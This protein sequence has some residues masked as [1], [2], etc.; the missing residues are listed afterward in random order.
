MFSLSRVLS[1]GLVALPY[2]SAVVHDV[3]VGAG[4]QLAFS[5]EAIA[6][7]PGDQV[8]FHF[9]PKNHT[10]TQ[11][12]FANPCG[13]KQG[14][15]DSGF[16]PVA[17]NSTQAPPTFAISVNDTQPIWV[18]CGQT[19]HCGKGMVF[20]VN[21]GAD[22]SAN[23]FTNFKKAALAQGAAASTGYPSP[24]TTATAPGTT[25]TASAGGQV[26]TVIVGGTNG[27]VYTPSNITAQPGDIVTFE[28]HSKNHTA[29]QSSFGA[30]CTPLNASGA[31]G[32]D[33]GFFP[34]SA[35]ATTFPTWNFT[36]QDT[37]PVWAYCAQTGHCRSGMVFAINA[38]PNSSKSYDAFLSNAKSGANGT[39]SG[40][41]SGSASSESPSPTSSSTG[42]GTGNGAMSVSVGGAG[43][44]F[45]TFLLLAWIL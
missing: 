30:P 29:T 28:F 42:S 2:V 3:Q 27:L 10:A 18:Y 8:V 40:S 32:F 38:D 31:T 23:S 5:P 13:L 25:S 33:S 35:T 11:S 17:A 16:E 14:G 22:G 6:A 15:F 45:A 7:Q 9:N 39:S 36:V 34:V 41:S 1:L 44:T 12:S 37:N 19:G 4:G 43:A 20:A 26:H 21:C 24:S